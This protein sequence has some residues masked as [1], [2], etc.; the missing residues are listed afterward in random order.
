MADQGA[1]VDQKQGERTHRILLVITAAECVFLAAGA[2]RFIR[3]AKR[4]HDAAGCAR[5]FVYAAS[6]WQALAG[7]QR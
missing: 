4:V 2:F 3:G 6:G 7:L 1:E 5:A